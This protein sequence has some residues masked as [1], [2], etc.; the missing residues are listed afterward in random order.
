MSP[1]L[2]VTAGLLAATIASAAAAQNSVTVGL[3]PQSA[4]AYFGSDQNEV[5]VTGNFS[6][7][8]LNFG[9]LRM[10]GS[11]GGAATGV[12]FTGSFR[13][14]GQ[15]KAA[16]YPELTG[17]ADLDAAL[18]IGGGLT[19]TADNFEVFGLARYGVMGHS[20][21]TGDLGA[22]AILRPT[23]QLTLRVGPRLF[24]GDDDYAQRYFGV[25]ATEAG[26]NQAAGY[27]LST[28]DASGGL[29]S[30]G[31]EVSADYAF[32]ADNGVT[33]M[34]RYD[35]Y[36]NG[37]ADSPIVQQGSNDAVTAAIL[38]THRFNF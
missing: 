14:I 23:D 30:R 21:L 8:Q 24:F 3:G 29:L 13:Y 2:R 27:S 20:S 5:G 35:E 10:G 4:P 37:A 19:Y 11:E 18:E 22:N 32:N 36:L 9:P 12:G 1:I 31:I 25:S 34:V 16:D 33:A 7:Q 38:L 15:R 17:L 28:Y 6:I 26:A